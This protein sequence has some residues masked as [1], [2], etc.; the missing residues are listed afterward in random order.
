[1]LQVAET[2]SIFDINGQLSQPKEGEKF[3]RFPINSTTDG[4]LLLGELQEV[5]PLKLPTILP[6]PEV[7][8]ALL[9]IINWRGKATWI[10]DLGSLWGASHW[11][12]GETIVESGMALLVRWK[13]ETIGLLIEE[14][15]TVEIF[16]SQQSLPIPE[17]MFSEQLSSLAQGYF[18]NPQGKTWVEL[19]ID[20]IMQTIDLFLINKD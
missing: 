2:I 4:L 11:C 14:I 8:Q 19:D 6:V 13:E 12:E 9:G 18:V 17:G 10:V 15:N 5:Y 3:L 20:S 7:N 16:N 1:M